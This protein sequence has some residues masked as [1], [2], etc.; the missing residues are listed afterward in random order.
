[1]LIWT[2]DSAL[3]NDAAVDQLV[4]PPATLPSFALTVPQN[5]VFFFRSTLLPEGEG[6]RASIIGSAQAPTPPVILFIAL[7]EPKDKPEPG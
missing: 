2:S 7:P 5:V 4:G 1:M 3:R 6:S